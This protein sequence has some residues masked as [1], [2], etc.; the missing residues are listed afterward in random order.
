[1][2]MLVFFVLLCR[3]TFDPSTSY[4]STRDVFVSFFRHNK[5]LTMLVIVHRP[6]W[7]DLSTPVYNLNR[8]YCITS[9]SVR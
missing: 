2:L 8:R 1:M 7:N 4:S 5:Y 3:I 6:T 9:D